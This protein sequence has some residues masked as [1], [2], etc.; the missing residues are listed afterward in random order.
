MACCEALDKDAANQQHKLAAVEFGNASGNGKSQAGVGCPDFESQFLF[1]FVSDP[2]P[3]RQYF[4]VIRIEV[5]VVSVGERQLLS[6]TQGLWQ[7]FHRLGINKVANQPL[8]N[9]RALSQFR[10][11]QFFQFMVALNIAPDGC[12]KR[13]QQNRRGDQ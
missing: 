1:I 12:N 3:S 6:L 4:V 5:D 13:N 9:S 11:K 2:Y 8:N 10:L 7:L